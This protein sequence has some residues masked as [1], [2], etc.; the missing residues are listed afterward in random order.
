[1]TPEELAIKLA[2]IYS[3]AYEAVLIDHYGA[4]FIEAGGQV[5]AEQAR[6]AHLIAEKVL[7][8]HDSA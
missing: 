4:A 3:R 6:V 7:D 2:D 5:S 1:M 8:S